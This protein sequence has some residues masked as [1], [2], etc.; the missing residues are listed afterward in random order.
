NDCTSFL[1]PRCYIV[2]DP[3]DLAVV[4]AAVLAACFGFLW[5]NAPPARIFMGDTGSLALGGGL[6]GLA[7]CT[8]T[9][10]LLAILGGLFVVIAISVLIPVGPLEATRPPVFRHS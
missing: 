3:L 8:K 2:R 7:G 9:Q 1:A 5:W 10:L 4:A 6:A